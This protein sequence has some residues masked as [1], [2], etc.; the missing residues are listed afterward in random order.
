MRAAPVPASDVF[1]LCAVLAHAATGEHPFEGA[2]FAQVESIMLRGPKA[3]A[4][5]ID[6]GLALDPRARPTPADILATLGRLSRR[7]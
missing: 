3:L 1:S 4:H 5:I 2:F 6:R 7:A